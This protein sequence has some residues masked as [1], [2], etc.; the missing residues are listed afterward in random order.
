MFGRRLY[1]MENMESVILE[2]DTQHGRFLT[3]VLGQESFG[4]EIT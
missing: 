2:E 3:F 1:S 4:L